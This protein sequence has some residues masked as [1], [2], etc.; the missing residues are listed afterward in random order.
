LVCSGN[1]RKA[2]NYMLDNVRLKMTDDDETLLRKCI[3]ILLGPESIEKTK[4]L[5]STQK[6]E[7]VNRSY[8]ACLPKNV[9]F[10][11]NCHGRIHGQILRLNH[12]LAD[13]VILKA[14][15]NGVKLSHGSSVIRHL[16][17]TE[18]YDKLRK[19]T[20]YISRAR[21]SRFASRQY[22]YKLHTDLHYSKGLTDPKPDFSST[23]HLKDHAYAYSVILE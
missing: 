6:C 13:T 16:L 12:G 1:Y 20:R 9:T 21:R 23:P 5:T 10:L 8:N 17:R 14:R 19:T 15:V 2:K 11:R 4:F 7:A 18:Y 3:E 22:R